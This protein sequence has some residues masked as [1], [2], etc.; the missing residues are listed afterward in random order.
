MKQFFNVVMA[1]LIAIAI[2]YFVPPIGFETSKMLLSCIAGVAVIA[3]GI[4][5]VRILKRTPE[6]TLKAIVV[7]ATIRG[8]IVIV[9]IIAARQW[10]PD[11]LFSCAVSIFIMYFAVQIAEIP[12]LKSLIQPKT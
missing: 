2:I 7:G 4:V 10:Y 12:W 5:Q 9:L 11:H 3:A 1:I 6:K 8:A